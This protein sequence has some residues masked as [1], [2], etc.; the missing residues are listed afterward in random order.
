MSKRIRGRTMEI[1]ALKFKRKS[2]KIKWQASMLFLEAFVAT[3]LN[4]QEK[5]K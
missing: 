5:E 1:H 2:S 4:K 3:Q